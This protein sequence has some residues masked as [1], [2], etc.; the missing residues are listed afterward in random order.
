MYVES[1]SDWHFELFKEILV[2]IKV[3]NAYIL[4]EHTHCFENMLH[5]CDDGENYQKEINYTLYQTVFVWIGVKFSCETSINGAIT[6]HSISN[7]AILVTLVQ[8][9]L[10][11]DWT[12]INSVWSPGQERR[13]VVQLQIQE[14]NEDLQEKYRIREDFKHLLP[15]RSL[16]SRRNP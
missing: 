4:S 13:S 9:P 2:F 3:F 10:F 15:A 16:I 1:N 11:K 14:Q 7:S 12:W 6:I 8:A 5:I